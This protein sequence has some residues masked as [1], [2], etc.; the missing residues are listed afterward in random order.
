[1]RQGKI[2]RA[3]PGS[4]TPE[5]FASHYP[6]GLKGLEQVFILKGGPGTGK[7][8]LMRQIGGAMR[9]RGYDVEF[10]Q[11]SSDNESLD[12]VVIPALSVAVIDG[13]PP[14]NVDPRYPGAV[15]E[16][17]D[18]GKH[19][20]RAA[21]RGHKQEIVSLTDEISGCFAA[22]YAQL[23]QAGKILAEQSMNAERDSDAISALTAELTKKI[24]HWEKDCREL[25]S[26]A[27]T[28]RGL[29]N[30]SESITADAKT[31][32]LLHGPAGCGKEQVIAALAGI[33]REKGHAVEIYHPALRPWETEVLL[34]PGLRLAVVDCGETP[35]A[36]A[37]EGDR[38]VDCGRLCKKTPADH[39]TEA[40]RLV[41]EAAA[42]FAQAKT[43]HD[44]LERYYCRAM[45]FDGVDAERSELFDRILDI[46]A[47]KE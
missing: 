1:M 23:A 36:E 42:H 15:E 31:R 33:A 9:E 34:L 30:Y 16:I 11:C 28:P 40:N 46:A 13:T 29:I 27:V 5:G 22:G 10:W 45:D 41:D 7:S 14:H 21:L 6:D 4:N 2:R 24:F 3:F 20:D 43:L 12:G 19:W 26:S 35:P 44:R 47:E 37:R 25:F 39:S 18:L 38:I 32:F 8:T 17:V